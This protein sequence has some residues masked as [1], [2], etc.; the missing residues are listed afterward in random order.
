MSDEMDFN[1]TVELEQN[2]KIKNEAIKICDEFFKNVKLKPSTYEDEGRF[3]VWSDSHN[4]TYVIIDGD[5]FYYE[6]KFLHEYYKMKITPEAVFKYIKNKY[7]GL[8]HLRVFVKGD[9]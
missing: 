2:I 3:K 9:K 4:S 8:G 7:M 1:Q 6:C 5:N